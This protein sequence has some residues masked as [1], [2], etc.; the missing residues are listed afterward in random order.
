MFRFDTTFKVDWALNIKNQESNSPLVFVLTPWGDVHSTQATTQSD[1]REGSLHSLAD[2]IA[3]SA[4]H[5]GSPVSCSVPKLC[6]PRREGEWCY[7]LVPNCGHT[8]KLSGNTA[9]YSSKN[10]LKEYTPKGTQ[11]QV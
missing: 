2:V 6:T 9:S 8:S 11:A 7:V 4:D 5:V 1:S 3:A 10:V